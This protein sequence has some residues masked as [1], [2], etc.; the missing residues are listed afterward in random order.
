MGLLGEL[1][2]LEAQEAGALR[3][4]RLM[5]AFI[6]NVKVDEEEAQGAVEAAL[7]EVVGPRIDKGY[8]TSRR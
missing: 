2:L 4:L 5:A 1:G 7:L 6:R 3:I 8:L